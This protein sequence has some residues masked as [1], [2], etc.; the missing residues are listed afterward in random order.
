MASYQDVIDRIDYLVAERPKAVI[1]AFLLV[2]LVMGA[3]LGSIST[4]SGTSQFTE[5]S[6]AMEAYDAVQ[7]EFSPAFSSSGGST[8]L[9]QRGQNVLAKPA[10]VR[11]LKAEHRMKEREELRVDTTSSPA[12]VIAVTLDPSADSLSEKIDAVEDA[13]PSEIDAA[14]RENADNPAFTSSVSDDFN[15][16]SASAT[17]AVGVVTHELPGGTS[18]SVGSSGSSPLMD[19]QLEAQHVVDSVGGDIT[20]FGAGILSQDFSNVIAD[21]LL[22]VVPAAALLIVAFLVYSYRDPFDLLLG[23]VSLVMAVIWTFGFMGLAGIAF[24]QMLIA[25]PPLLLAVGI[26][27]GIHAV[28][29]YREERV[30]GHGVVESMETTTDQLLVAFF[31]VTG[32]TV[33]G[34]LSN[35]T[36][37]LGP[38]KDFGLVAAIGITFTLLVFGI[39]LPAGKVFIDTFRE[40]RDIPAF[41]LRPIGG[42]GSLLGRVLPAGVVVAKKAPY[43]FLI[44]IVLFTAGAG[45]YGTG[46]NTSFNQ[47]DFLPP[48]DTPAY[49]DSL[50]EP[51]APSEYTAT[52]QT[53][54]LT[55]HFSRVGGSSVTVYVTGPMR[56]DDSLEQIRHASASPPSSVAAANRTADA[57]SIIGVIQSYADASPS[58]A[59]LVERNDVNDNGVPDDN[60]EVIYDELMESPYSGQASQYLAEDYR[61][62]KVDYTIEASASQDEAAAAA[63]SL[64]DRYHSNSIGT[65]QPVIFQALT[66][67]ILNS[68]LRSL[69]TAILAALVFLVIC[70]WG[71]ERR[72]SLGLVNMVPILVTIAWLAGAMRFLNIPFNAMT[73][74]IL[75][76]S[77]G[78]GVDYSSHIVH[79]FA[80]EYDGDVVPAVETSIRGTGGALA[81]SMFTTVSGIGVL[82]IAITPI[83]GQFGTV[84]A[85]SIFFSFLAAVIV[86][87]S[88]FVVWHDLQARFGTAPDAV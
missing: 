15:A 76:I 6:D 26:D 5:G 7:D 75:S 22:I 10:L 56:Q 73:A 87:P 11:M 64:A 29:R 12:D 33:L 78:L 18:S 1:V 82:A 47:D 34:F 60:L 67:V 68:A 24:S 40:E 38:I 88:V 46:V 65:G 27:F 19:I 21:S 9:I 8:Q 52:A 85:L 63:E 54:F 83:L 4:Q 71:F 49:L 79:R 31:I 58:F 25:V 66:S 14:V 39:F 74:T 53:N 70:F 35:L 81:G 41:G 23:I 43:V 16:P 57:S 59:R 28:N 51:F 42:E 20:V 77:I 61:S 84:T 13:T 2:T 36:S 62:M 30:D 44:C 3:G 32:T 55:D 69:V 50:P 17:A 80:D 86:T 45:Y 48:E 37:S 72:P